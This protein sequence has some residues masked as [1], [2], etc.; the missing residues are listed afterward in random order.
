MLGTS[1]TPSDPR[2]VCANEEDTGDEE[3]GKQFVWETL[4]AHNV[5]YMTV[6]ATDQVAVIGVGKAGGY[7]C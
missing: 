3:C 2:D 1:E 7:I 4:S 6:D 5:G